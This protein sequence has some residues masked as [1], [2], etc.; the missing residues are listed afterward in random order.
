M[1][2]NRIIVDDGVDGVSVAPEDVR[3]YN[4]VTWS[5]TTKIAV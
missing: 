1:G 4:D 5:T 3:V 2:T